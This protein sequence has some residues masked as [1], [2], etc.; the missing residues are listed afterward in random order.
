M[1]NALHSLGRV[2]H[3]MQRERGCVI[4]FLCS[5]G[6]FYKDKI[7]QCF[8]DCDYAVEELT[9]NFPGWGKEDH[10][11]TSNLEKMTFLLENIAKVTLDRDHITSLELS[12]GDAFQIYSHKI[13]GPIIDVMVNIA[14]ND[15][16]NSSSRVSAYANFLHLK[17]RIG[18]ER[19]LGS[20]GL[21]LDAFEN[22]EFLENYRF[23]IS[24]QNSYHDTF[25]ALATE[26]Q[27]ACFHRHMDD[28]SVK[29]IEEMHQFLNNEDN[30]QVYDISPMDWYELTTQK[31]NLMHQVEL[32]L[33]GTLAEKDTD[34]QSNK[35]G[36]AGGAIIEQKYKDFILTLPVFK[37][38]SENTLDGL[39]RNAT[40]KEYT[41]G[42]L[43]F[44]EG[45]QANRLYIIMQGWVK[46]CKG[47][48]SGD[49]T[50][51]Q[52]LTCGDMVLESAVFLNAPYPLNAQV[53]KKALVL[54]LPAPIIRE[55][56]KTNNKLALNVLNGMSLH[57]QILIQNIESVRL[58]SATERVGWFFLKL[59]LDQGRV[60]DMVEL[61]YDKSLIASYLDMKPETFSRTLKKFKHKGFEIR[62]DAVILPSVNA[63]CGFCD[64]DT[65]S[66]CSRH[67]T[68]DCPNPDCDP[69]EMQSF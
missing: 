8:R 24:E 15:L 10:L 13:V 19:V 30:S 60:P 52:M 59:L 39:L 43:L 42:N 65:A 26:R 31:I 28:Y 54:S 16:N 63:L 9:S 50:I 66:A 12:V 29:R 17:E 62:K 20:R 6:G 22:S 41:K 40:I 7:N 68:P 57:S 38:L 36:K 61:P 11:S 44:L 67:G 58:K 56:V 1:K 69:S 35:F 25:F 5:K 55:Q 33:I 14:L 45:E 21:V 37:G 51:L 46:V 4:L 47:N 27:K 34:E 49:E 3:E 48:S 23:L 18:R 64:A 53:T 2:L 32:D